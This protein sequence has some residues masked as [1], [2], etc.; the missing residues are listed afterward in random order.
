MI[1]L[2]TKLTSSVVYNP[3]ESRRN[4]QS[5]RQHVYCIILVTSVVYNPPDNKFNVQSYRQHVSCVILLTSGVMYNPTEI[6]A[7]YNP[8]DSTCNVRVQSYRQMCSA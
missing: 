3:P 1:L 5:Y 4:V 8:T 2:T 7:V 6:G